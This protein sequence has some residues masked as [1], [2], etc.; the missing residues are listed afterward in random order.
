M[1]FFLG[2]IMG[3]VTLCEYIW[4]MVTLP[5]RRPR[6]DHDQESQ[7]DEELISFKEMLST[8]P[9]QSGF[10]YTLSRLL[11]HTRRRREWDEEESIETKV[12]RRRG[13][14]SVGIWNGREYGVEE[15]TGYVR[16]RSMLG[17]GLRVSAWEG[18]YGGWLQPC[19]R[20]EVL[21]RRG[22]G[23]VINGERW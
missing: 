6:T 23:V 11:K 10:R 12:A 14:N 4:R 9:T 15:E 17:S 5:F 1:V 21:R 2:L 16:L 7:D 3:P 13:V 8:E 20:K 18:K 22:F 19:V